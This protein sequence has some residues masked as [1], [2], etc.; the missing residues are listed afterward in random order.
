MDLLIEN[1]PFV[2]NYNTIVHYQH[3]Y[4]KYFSLSYSAVKFYI[5]LI[6]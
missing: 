6:I 1:K 5:Q 4:K 2:G 3:E